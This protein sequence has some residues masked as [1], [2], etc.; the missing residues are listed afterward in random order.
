MMWSLG[1][2]ILYCCIFREFIQGDGEHSGEGSG[3]MKQE[4]DEALVDFIVK[5]SQPF[6][7]SKPRPPSQ[8]IPSHTSLLCSL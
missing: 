8:T 5:E 6:S 2:R 3:S 1:G 7:V 4:L